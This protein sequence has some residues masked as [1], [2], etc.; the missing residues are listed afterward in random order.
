MSKDKSGRADVD[1]PPFDICERTFQFAVR[2]VHVCEL[3]DERPGVRWTLSKQLLGAGTSIGANLEEAQ[4]GQSRADFISK[5]SIARKEAR[6]T[7]YWLRILIACRLA[8]HSVVTPLIAECDELC[9]ILTTIIKKCQSANTP[10][11]KT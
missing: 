9:K 3:L 2:I 4:C 11:K 8:D 5:Y 1:K 7:K 6:E 10:N